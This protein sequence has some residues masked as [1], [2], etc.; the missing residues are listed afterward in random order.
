VQPLSN[1]RVNVTWPSVAGKI[2]VIHGST[3]GQTWQPFSAPLT[4]T[5][6]QMNHTFTPPN[7]RD[8]CFLRIEVLR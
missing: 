8:F 2:Y 4:A 3:D 6:L 7:A 1:D 5:G